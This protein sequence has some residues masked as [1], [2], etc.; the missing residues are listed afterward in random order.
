MNVID[1]NL[2]FG[3]FSAASN[4]AW[5]TQILQDIRKA[6]T[7]EKQAVYENTMRWKTYE[8]ITIEPFYTQQDIQNIP[9]TNLATATQSWQ[10]RQ[11][12]LVK[13]ARETNTTALEAI[14]GGADAL[15]LEISEDTA[16]IDLL[17]LLQNI[18]LSDTPVSFQ[19]GNISTDFLQ[20][21]SLVAPYQ[22][23]GSLV[24]DPL[25]D[26][27]SQKGAKLDE[28]FDSL[29]NAFLITQ[30][31]PHFR[32]LTVKSHHVHE[33]GASVVQE[34]AFLLNT[35]VE[36]AHQ[37]TERG[38]AIEDVFAGTELS[39]SVSTNYF[40]EIAKFRALPLLWQQ[41]AKA[42]QIQPDAMYMHARTALWNKPA[43][44][45]YNNM[46]RATIEA[47]AATLGGVNSVT[48]LPYNHD[49]DDAFAIR[50]ARN[51]SVILKEESYL[52]K[53]LNVASGSYYIEYLTHRFAAEAWK[54]FQ[55]V[56]ARGG[57]MQAT[58]DGFIQEQITAVGK[59]KEADY[60]SGK[61]VLVGVNKY[62]PEKL[63]ESGFIEFKEL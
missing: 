48:V 26:H 62:A 28:A 49:T 44:D 46:I 52:D 12:I 6:T 58:K 31:H 16:G 51:V 9:A 32:T 39:L 2:S 42:Y 37:L 1:K 7:E 29:A 47:M 20:Q 36:Y 33:A 40:A 18:K 8:G 10:N 30:K 41:M 45:A 3:E 4:H 34:L 23:K 17:R 21:L 14:R 63:S 43:A 5:K 25:A 15:L 19:L 35:F 61:Q 27:L 57:F 11:Y 53:V 22:W 50:I 13:D 55:I 56:E 38:I 60:K 59:A 24:Y 54:L